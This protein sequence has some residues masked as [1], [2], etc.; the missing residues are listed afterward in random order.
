MFAVIKTGGKQYRVAPNDVL[1]IERVAGQPGDTVELGSVLAVGG[2]AGVTLGAPLVEGAMVAAQVLE[3]ARADKV[4]VF[5]KKRR[6]NHRRRHGHRQH[7]TVLRVTEILTDGKK[8]SKA[9]AKPAP[10]AAA[11]APEAETAE[12]APKKAAAKKA[13]KTAPAK[14]APAKKAPAKKAAPKKAAAK[15]TAAKKGAKKSAKKEE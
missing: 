15:K 5:K 3:Q 6:K 10:A 2:E 14:K 13:A 8:P 9:K 1:R 7:E 11:P 4:I 12:K